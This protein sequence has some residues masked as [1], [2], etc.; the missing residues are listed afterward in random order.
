MNRYVIGVDTGGTFTDAV[1]L[2]YRTRKV[3]SSAKSLTTRHDLKAGVVEVIDKLKIEQPDKVKL[4]G[5]SSTLATN[6]I[7]EGKARKVGLLL[8]GYDRNL[9]ENYGLADKFST[10]TIGHIEGGHDSQGRE[11]APLDVDAL[12][13]WVEKHKDSVDALAVSSYFSPLDP[14]HEEIA[15]REIQEICNLPIVMGH[16]LSTRLDSI[17]RASTACINASLVAVMQEFIEAV[18]LSLE[19]HEIRAPL[20]IVRGDGTLMPYPEA[21]AKPVET[22]LSGPA[23]SANGGRFLAKQKNSLVIDIG[24]TTTDM[25]LVEDGRVVVSNNGTRVGDTETAIEAARIRT[26][27]IG[28]DSRIK[29]DANRNIEVGPERVVALSQMAKLFPEAGKKLTG[30]KNRNPVTW[31][32]TELEFRI[33]NKSLE[34]D[35]LESLSDKA[36]KVVN[37][38]LNG[39][40]SVAE[41]MKE[42]S[43]YH[44]AQLDCEDLMRQGYLETAALTPSDLLHVS[45]N[46]DLWDEDAARQAVRCCCRIHQRERDEFIEEVLDLIVRKIVE[47]IIIFLAC[48]GL[49]EQKMPPSIDG[50]WG[51]WLLEELFTDESAY[52]SVN[53]DGRFP[54]IGTGAPA[55]FF[56]RQAA[57]IMSTPFVC[58]SHYQ[59]A[60]AVGAVS[61][62]IMG[63]REARVFE[64]LNKDSH[65]HV[66]QIQEHK[67]TFDNRDDALDYAETVCEKYAREEALSAG[68]YEPFVEV[69]RNVEGALTRFVARAV[70]NPRLSM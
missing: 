58:P 14:E 47:E 67:K 53:V 65:L 64:Q 62:S 50:E 38:L 8:I 11:K 44:P 13:A 5:I 22:V 27:C 6:S 29:F 9:I 70:G 32:A 56:I 26:L 28:C 42:V 25:A 66:V 35:V 1:L 49:P 18:R 12:R 31:K 37:L 24:S 39:P 54:I 21:V 48:Q 46:M 4:V 63:T 60:N 61:G 23:A 45:G 52:L 20:M 41:L 2:H 68:A 69:S 59:V 34:A 3:V 16:Q 19:Q 30:L 43:V 36:R 40:M 57:E 17:K 55:K 33:L 51:R 7:A 10:D 15:F